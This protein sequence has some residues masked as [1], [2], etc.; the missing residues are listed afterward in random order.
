R[1]VSLLRRPSVCQPDGTPDVA[2]SV[3]RS[4]LMNKQSA[5]RWLTVCLAG[6]ALVASAALAQKKYRLRDAYSAGD[7][8]AVDS[9][10]DMNLTVQI[11][12]N[13]EDSGQFIFFKRDREVY[14]EKV[15]AADARGPSAIQRIYTVARGVFTD[16]TGQ[17]H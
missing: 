13:G 4:K 10:D 2:A 15:I 3:S 5:A 12:A 9:S 1:S 8:C 16:A 7:L 6:G 17:E 11:K 14:Q